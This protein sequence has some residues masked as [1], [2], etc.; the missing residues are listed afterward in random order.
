MSP[1]RAYVRR[2]RLVGAGYTVRRRGPDGQLEVVVESA[3]RGEEMTLDAQGLAQ[4]LFSGAAAPEGWSVADIEEEIR[5]Q[6]G[7]YRAARSR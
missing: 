6:I 3:S 5:A 1:S 7:A 2:C 4:A